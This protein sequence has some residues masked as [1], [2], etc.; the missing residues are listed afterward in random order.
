M[1]KERK[2]EI[3]DLIENK[4]KKKEQEN[5]KTKWNKNASFNNSE[6]K[7]SQSFIPW[8]KLAVNLVSVVCCRTNCVPLLLSHRHQTLGQVNSLALE[9][10][11]FNTHVIYDALTNVN[12]VCLCCI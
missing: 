1:E 5:Y 9:Y 11:Q 7:N 6:E 10:M 3:V 2:K 4:K 12:G 8:E